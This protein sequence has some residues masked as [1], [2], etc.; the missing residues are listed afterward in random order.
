MSKILVIDDDV[1]IQRLV[2]YKLG[3][4]GH[5]V[6]LAADGDTGYNLATAEKP[7]LIISDVMMPAADGFQVLRRIKADESLKDVPVL[8]LTSKRKD[9]DIETGL[10]LGA[11]DYMIKPFSP[12]ELLA[13]VKKALTP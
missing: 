13:R 3:Q 11:A 8:L 1:T 10:D 7:D 5:T 9:K 4:E 6:L 12:R 2:Q